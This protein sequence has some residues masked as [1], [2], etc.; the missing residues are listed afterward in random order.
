MN[1]EILYGYDWRLLS[2]AESIVQLLEE[3]SAQSLRSSV[4]DLDRTD[5]ISAEVAEDTIL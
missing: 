2:P 3:K 4:K 1:V 5:P